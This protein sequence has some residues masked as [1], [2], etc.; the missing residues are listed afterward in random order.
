MDKDVI[1]RRLESLVPQDLPNNVVNGRAFRMEENEN[2]EEP[3][4]SKY[5]T[6]IINELNKRTDE[7]TTTLNVRVG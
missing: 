4:E 5:G 2:N 3:L 6:K 7:R 1:G